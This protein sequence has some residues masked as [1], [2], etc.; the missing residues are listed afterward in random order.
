MK[1]IQSVNV[2]GMGALG[3]LYANLIQ[4]NVG[5]E[6]VSFLLDDQRYGKYKDTVFTING[7]QKTFQM[8]KESQAVPVD[9]VIVA[10]KF[11]GL[12]ACLK[13][14]EKV[15]GPDTVII[16]V[17]NGISSEEYIG[18]KFGFEK[19]LHTVAQ[20]MDAMKFETSMRYTKVGELRIGYAKGGTLENLERVEAFFEKAGIPY[21]EEKDIIRRLWNKFMC[22][23]GINQT[24]MVYGMNYSQVL[25]PG[26]A[27]DTFIGAMKEVILISQAEGI[28]LTLED[29]QNWVKILSS[30]DPEGTPSMG[31]DRLCKR[32]SEV[33]LF[34]GTVLKIAKKHGI[35][36]PVN[37]W[38]YNQVQ[39]IESQYK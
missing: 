30:L 38:L 21:T 4:S 6:S 18:A 3:L 39:K 32:K 35:E 22:N 12:E 8:V 20:A 29:L 19:V 16:S 9:L 2:I 25:A 28:N 10:V 11:T 17:L 13:T 37:K 26:K 33:E 5:A 24:C 34:S 1:E 31:Q 36:V 15:V 7:E 14:M 23:V 27:N